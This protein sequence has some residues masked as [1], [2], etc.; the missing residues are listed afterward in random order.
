ML[1]KT[2]FVLFLNKVLEGNTAKEAMTPFRVAINT[3]M[4]QM[5]AEVINNLSR[6]DLS[7]NKMGNK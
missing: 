4:K 7:L 3:K 5:T 6:C 2:A 1:N